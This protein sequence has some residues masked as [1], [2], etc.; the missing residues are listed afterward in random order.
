MTTV[1]RWWDEASSAWL[2]RVVSGAE[3]DPRKK[4]LFVELADAA[5]ADRQAAIL[6]GDFGVSAP[7]FVPRLRLRVVARL[8][9]LLGPRAARPPLARPRG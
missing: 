5:D 7:R 3:P 6:A 2:Y 1:E 4:R 9:R 8:T